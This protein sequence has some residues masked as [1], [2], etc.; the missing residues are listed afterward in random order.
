MKVKGFSPFRAATIANTETHNAAMY[1]LKE[2][3]K[4]VAREE[5][6]DLRKYWIPVEDSRTRDAHSAMASHDAIPLDALFTVGG[7]KMDRPGD[8][9]ASAKNVIRCRCTMAYSVAE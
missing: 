1:A 7:E 5:N 8:P 2:N 4:R 6:L 9:R 3:G